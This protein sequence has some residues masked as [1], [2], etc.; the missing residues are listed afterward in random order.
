MARVSKK[1]RSR[2]RPTPAGA[3]GRE[4]P[5][6]LVE[7]MMGSLW[8][9]VAAGDLLRAELEAATCMALP[10]VGQLSPE[11]AQGF[12]SKVLVDEAIRQP[13]ADGAAM[14]RLLM[15]LGSPAT[16]RSASRALARLTEAGIYPPD[17]VTEAGKAVPVQAWRR[18]DVF[19]DDEAVVVTFRYGEAEHGIVAQIDL[20]G[21]PAAV[22]V[23]VAAD[24][25]SLIEA[26]R[27]EDDPFDR[28][29]RIGLAEARRRLETPLARGDEEAGPNLS[30]DTLA[31]LP[32][33][34]S[35][36]RRLPAEGAEPVPVLGAADRAAAVDDFLKS[37][38]AAEAVAAD[39]DATRFWAEV[40]TGY[41]SRIPGEPPGQVG[42]RKIAHLLLGY[43]PNTFSLSPAQRQHLEPAVTAW[44]RWSAGYRGL[45]EAATARL[46]ESLPGVFGRFGQAYDD[47]DAAT[48][49]SYLADL[50]VSDADASRLA[51][52]VARRM[53]AVPSPGLAEDG[54]PVDV[55][56]P[57]VRRA[58]IEAE[59][60][61]CTPHAG[62]T[63][64]EFMAAVHRVIG[65]LWDDD[66]VETFQTARR[67][68]VSGADRHDIIHTLA[69]TPAAP[70]G[71][72]SPAAAGSQP[73]PAAAG[74]QAA[75]AAPGGQA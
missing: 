12:I 47:P 13:S 16:K 31:Y 28:T 1:T 51:G 71:Q 65:E 22:A 25:A 29:E 15:S 34:R 43:V 39:E 33:A 26:M 6:T 20:T 3:P 57:A 4:D 11:D 7:R 72:P 37:P 21:I 58:L 23:G 38:L 56:D 10:R 68:Y 61:E 19:G 62:L 14:L 70:G 45:D 55:S 42:P 63:R 53:F 75:P 66:P 48:A 2:R 74:S 50:A 49:R 30:V 17:W 24:A 41:C 44:T 64:E 9:A 36:V 67:W 8:Q 18:Y 52:H 54:G 35:R 46:T 32:V 59:F 69:E 73:A 27:R 40:L 5:G 60:A